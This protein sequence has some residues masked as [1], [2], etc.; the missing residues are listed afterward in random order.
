MGQKSYNGAGLSEILKSAD[1][2]KG[3]FYHYFKSKE[4]FA[5]AVIERSSEEHIARMKEMMSDTSKTPMERIY[6]YFDMMREH[7]R[8]NGAQ[9]NC[10][11]AKLALE[12]C[13]LSLP[14]RSAVKIAYD[15]W[16]L[17]LSQV[18]AELQSSAEFSH[19]NDVE[20]LAIA[21]VLINDWEGA[22]MRM[23]IEGTIKPLD[24]FFDVILEHGLKMK[25]CQIA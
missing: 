23:Q 1:V 11:I 15:Q 5:V 16:A 10:L 2:P 19:I 25:P 18:I 13:Q 21:N 3:S 20:A 8:E 9:R 12:V 14:L 4:D 22:T 17:V 24:D 6:G 7:Y